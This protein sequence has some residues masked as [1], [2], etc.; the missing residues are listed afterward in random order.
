MTDTKKLSRRK[1]LANTAA[2]SAAT[3]LPVGGAYA[4]DASLFYRSGDYTYC[5]AK[6]LGSYW[7]RSP[8][9]AKVLAGQKIQAG[10]ASV[11]KQVAKQAVR[12]AEQ[13]GIRCTFAD[14]DNPAYTYNDAALLARYWNRKWGGKMTPNDAKTKIVINLPGGGNGWVRRELANARRGG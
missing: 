4:Q 5:D 1:L 10:G 14:A 13:R 6:M 7:N 8:W 3:A 12:V 9:D 2:F 11:L